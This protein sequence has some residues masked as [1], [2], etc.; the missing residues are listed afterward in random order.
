MKQKQIQRIHERVLR[1]NLREA[2]FK[3]EIQIS[4]NF[5]TNQELVLM[6]EPFSEEWHKVYNKGFINYVRGNWP[7]AISKFHK[8]LQMKPDDKPTINLLSFMSSLNNEVPKDWQGY[9]YF[10]EWLNRYLKL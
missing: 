1:N 7:S 9:K 4:D 8:I 3:E 5:S 2:A 10:E 6:R